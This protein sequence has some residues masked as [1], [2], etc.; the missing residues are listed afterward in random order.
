M[1]FTLMAGVS[2]GDVLSLRNGDTLTGSIAAL[3]DGVV[4][5][6]SEVAGEVEVAAEDIVCLESDRE[7]AFFLA[8]GSSFTGTVECLGEGRI[9]MVGSDDPAKE[10]GDGEAVRELAF[11]EIQSLQKEEPEK[12][13]THKGK[14]NAAGVRTNGNESSKSLNVSG[15]LVSSYK[16]HRLNL[17]SEYNY[18]ESEDD[19]TAEN[20]LA[21]VQYDYFLSKRIFTYLQGLYE[22]DRVAG[23][24]RRLTSG[25][26]L[27]YQLLET[28]RNQ[29]SL[30]AGIS[31]VNEHNDNAANRDYEAARWAVRFESVLVADTLDFFHYHEGYDRLD[32]SRT[33]LI[34]SSQGLRLK[35]SGNLYT[36]LQVDYDY[37]ND[38]PPGNRRSVVK[39]IIGLSYDFSL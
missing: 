31:H 35:V 34:R 3:D 36:N 7:L 20:F 14:L 26:G 22:K 28:E 23:L 15:R 30:E 11:S 33:L 32:D 4:V 1:V 10:A 13:L 39:Y 17:E 24:D 6:E 19:L 25:A 29:L 2:A 37:D 5:F 9:R 16:K 27:G 8:D 12:G 18:A 38:P 21:G